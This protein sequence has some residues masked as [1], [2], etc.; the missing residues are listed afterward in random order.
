MTD[1]K[2]IKPYNYPSYHHAALN[3]VIDGSN[4][5]RARQLVA[6]CLRQYRY[7][8]YKDVARQFLHHITWVGYPMKKTR[9]SDA[10]P[11]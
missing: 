3:A 1:A 5:K 7:H 6:M 8:G 9:T 10:N 4:P 2:W 11:S